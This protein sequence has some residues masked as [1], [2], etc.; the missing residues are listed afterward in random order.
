MS[1]EFEFS[2]TNPEIS[3]EFDLNLVEKLK[4]NPVELI[5]EKSKI[6]PE[7]LKK[8]FP[9]KKILA[10]DFCVVGIE[11][12]KENEGGFENF[13]ILNIDHHTPAKRMEKMIS[14][15]NLA[16]EYVKKHG[17]ISKDYVTAI[18]HTDTDSILSSAIMRGILEPKEEFSMAAIASD[19]TGEKNEIG[20]LLQALQA[21]RNM[22]FSLRNLQLLLENKPLEQKAQELL[23][24][25]LK[26]RDRAKEIIE[27]GKFKKEGKVSYA[28]LEEKIDG[29][30]LP[31]LLPDAKVILLA[32]PLKANPSKWEIKLRLG[33]N[34]PEGFI[35]DKKLLSQKLDSN[36]GGRWNAGSNKRSIDGIET[37]GGT[38]M[39]PEKYAKKLDELIIGAV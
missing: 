32:S 27:S 18:N 6:T 21:E 1:K 29:G 19:H 2:T 39:T 17:P 11:K 13:D 12:G 34:I 5:E 15:T 37:R 10:C 22:E 3:K 8:R 26:D 33:K 16:T 31:A 7:E 30:L 25:R 35:L 14:S 28:I 38:D 4:E 36:Y 9:N 23:E 20:D 24:R